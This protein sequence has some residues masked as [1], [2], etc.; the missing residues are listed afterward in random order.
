M[1]QGRTAAL[2]LGMFCLVSLIAGSAI[3]GGLGTSGP[4]GISFGPELAP[5]HDVKL[6]T[7]YFLSYGPDLARVV[8]SPVKWAPSDWVKVAIVAGL[9]SAV[10]D[11]DAGIQAWIQRNRTKGTDR[12]ARIGEPLGNGRYLFPTLGLTYC[13]GRMFGDERVQRA[14]LL[15]IES[16]VISGAVTG[17][18]KYLAHKRRPFETAPGEDDV[19]WSGPGLNSKDLSFPSGHTTAAFAV[20]T[21]MASEYRDHRIVPPLAYTA[22]SLVGFSRLNSNSHWLSDVIVG[23]AI[24]HF[25]ARAVESIHGGTGDKSLSLAPVVDENGVGL[26]LAVKF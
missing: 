6:G 3:A 16:V 25:T 14:S 15:S 20:A 12:L 21:I 5:D 24:G 2:V 17:G 23:A 9:A 10:S 13:Y 26:S 8:T 1:R 4:V 19:P 11:R 22:A 7:D 18:I